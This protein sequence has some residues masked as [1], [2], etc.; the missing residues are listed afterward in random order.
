MYLTYTYTSGAKKIPR[1][2]TTADKAPFQLTSRAEEEALFLASNSQREHEVGKDTPI[3]SHRILYSELLAT[4][5]SHKDE[6]GNE[7]EPQ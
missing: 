1:S 3:G 5:H 2:T 4:Q 7:A 6:A